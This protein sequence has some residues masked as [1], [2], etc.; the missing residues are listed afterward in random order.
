MI[1]IPKELIEKLDARYPNVHPQ[2]GFD[3]RAVDVMAGALEVV[4]FIK[5]L[6]LQSERTV[7]S[8]VLQTQGPQP[9]DS[10]GPH[11]DR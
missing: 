3:Q 4:A 6:K 1:F 8:N 7:P 2:P 5:A 9:K 11:G 10:P